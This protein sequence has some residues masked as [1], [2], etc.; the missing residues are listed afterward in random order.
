MRVTTNTKLNDKNLIRPINTKVIPV[1][2]YAMNVCKFTQLEL[3]E[4]DQIIKRKLRKKKNMLGWQSS[5]ERLYMK[6]S[7]GGRGLK[8][9]REVFEETRLHVECYMATAENKWIKAA[10]RLETWKENDSVINNAIN[11]EANG[12]W[13]RDHQTC[14]GNTKQWLETNM[15]ESENLL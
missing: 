14:G 13:R 11:R 15:E 3:V 8:S 12:I 10:W 9:M 7:T 1:A 4:L 2:A 5:D 6:R